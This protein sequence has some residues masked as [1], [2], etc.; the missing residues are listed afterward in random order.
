MTRRE[1]NASQFI[2][3]YCI[4]INK[5]LVINMYIIKYINIIYILYFLKKDYYLKIFK[6]GL[7]I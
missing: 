3:K 7:Y 2:K 4:I 1:R 6:S 5:L